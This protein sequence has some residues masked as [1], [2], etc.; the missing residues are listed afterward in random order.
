MQPLR[1]FDLY[2]SYAQF[3][4][5]DTT[6]RDAAI[7]WGD[8]HAAQGFVQSRS[9]AA[10]GTLLS[11]G[12]AR[13]R[14]FGQEPSDLQQYDRVIALPLE[15]TSDRVSFTD[16]EALPAEAMTIEMAPGHYRLIIAQRLEDEGR[17]ESI[18]VFFDKLAVPLP[19]GSILVVDGA[20]APPDPLVGDAVIR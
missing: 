19:H 15:L 4:I 5:F 14:V 20:L 6:M 11:H 16:P 7:D 8:D 1:E 18:D 13:T 17:R 9:I 10:I 12:V 3:L 2:F